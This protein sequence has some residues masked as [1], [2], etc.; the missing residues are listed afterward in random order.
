MGL[1]PYDGMPDSPARSNIPG[2]ITE[3]QGWGCNS[4]CHHY[5]INPGIPNVSGKLIAL[6]H[7]HYREWCAYYYDR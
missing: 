7:E 4:L 3:C 2:D 1:T 6:C 5:V